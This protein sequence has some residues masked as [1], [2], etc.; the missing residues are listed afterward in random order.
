MH[1]T[2][3]RPSGESATASSRSDPLW[4]VRLLLPLLPILALSL[5]PLALPLTPPLLALLLQTLLIASLLLHHALHLRRTLRTLKRRLLT[6]PPPLLPHTRTLTNP[7]SRALQPLE[8]A[9][10][11]TLGQTHTRLQ[12]LTAESHLYHTVLTHMEEGIVVTDGRLRI[13][14]ANPRAL[15]ILSLP[16]EHRLKPLP[17]F[18]RSTSLLEHI[19][20]TLSSGTPLTHTLTTP[21]PSSRTIR[22]HLI[23]LPPSPSERLLL[24][25]SD[26]TR[27]ERLEQIRRDFVSSV[28]HELKTPITTV[29][30]YLETLKDLPP[31]D[32]ATRTRFL[33]TALSHTHRLHQIIEDL[34]LLS[35]IEQAEAPVPLERAPLAPLIRR[36]VELVRQARGETHPLTL[37]G[38]EDLA[39]P[40]NP[41]LMVQALYNLIHNALTH[42]PPGTPVVVRW[43]STGSSVLI[44]VED[45]GPGIP[46][47]ALPRIFER[48]YR[49]DTSRSRATGGTGLGLSIVKHIVQAHKG[50]IDVHSTPGHGTTFTIRLPG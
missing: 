18:L 49:V 10:L 19:H 46:P 8:E 26:I 29:L 24:V 27:L 2:T 20:R 3:S 34:L 38:P 16:P 28:S 45:R 41:G 6:T 47:E 37:E 42:T 14:Y 11:H 50:T 1:E 33:E 32:E 22:L 23:P 15:E 13:T 21:P 43:R 48:F 17:Q 36:A 9:L 12:D 39:L 25:A 30:G 31:D 5:L 35:R 44:Q 7:F 40:L 4:P